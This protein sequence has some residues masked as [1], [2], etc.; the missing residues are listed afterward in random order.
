MSYR[1]SVGLR[2][3]RFTRR[4]FVPVTFRPPH[5][6]R[7]FSITFAN[8]NSQKV[9]TRFS[10][11]QPGSPKDSLT[12]T[13]ARPLAKNTKASSAS[14]VTREL[15]ST[16]EPIVSLEE[17]RPFP[18]QDL[19]TTRPAPLTTPEPP[20]RHE[21]DGPIPISVRLSYLY[22]LGK[23]YVSFYKTG[24]KNIWLNYK[25]YRNIQQ[26]LGSLP[27]NEVAKYSG[28]DGYPTIS[29]REYQLC[30]RTRHDVKKLI[31]FGLILLICGEFTPLVVVALGSAVVPSTCRIPRQ[32]VKDQTNLL[33][34]V[35]EV[36]RNAK[37]NGSSL[38]SLASLEARLGYIWGLMPSPRPLPL[39]HSLLRPRV[40]RRAEELLCDTIL[41][42]R[43]G[44]VAQ[45]EPRELL[46]FAQQASLTSLLVAMGRPGRP[47]MLH[48]GAEKLKKLVV[49]VFE[50]FNSETLQVLRKVEKHP[51]QHYMAGLRF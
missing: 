43:E 5:L 18:D 17:T 47:G 34:R 10:G 21:Y 51:E 16:E 27:L 19:S 6:L 2:A 1:I 41:L 8:D 11:P 42:R 40:K 38:E 49:P 15:S 23:S 46:Y 14:P 26:R 7:P 12:E 4:S 36:N 35:Y 48:V 25:E 20:Q 37:S 32:V 28:R 33:K 3:S 45:L 29:R 13:S 31:P 39:I 50:E 30:L 24:L 44:G 22:R 9:R